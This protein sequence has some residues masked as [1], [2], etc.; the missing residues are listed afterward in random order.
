MAVQILVLEA[1]IPIGFRNA[2]LG[3]IAQNQEA[4][5]YIPIDGPVWLFA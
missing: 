5:L 3:V 1:Q 2:V 4:E